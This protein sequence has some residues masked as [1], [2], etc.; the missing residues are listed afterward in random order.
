[1]LIKPLMSA[2]RKIIEKIGFEFISL[3]NERKM[4]ELSEMFCN[5]TY[6]VSPLVK[7]LFP[8]SKTDRIDGKEKVKEYYKRLVKKNPDFYLKYNESYFDIKSKKFKYDALLRNGNHI[9]SQISINEQ[10]K[11]EYI[12][13]EYLND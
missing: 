6:L 3:F 12:I 8:E 2:L 5:T 13:T 7:D 9:V 1:M 10:G 4:D 11:I